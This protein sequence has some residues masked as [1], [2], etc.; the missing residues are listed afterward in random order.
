MENIRKNYAFLNQVFILYIA[1]FANVKNNNSWSNED[2]FLDFLYE[3]NMTTK[4]ADHKVKIKMQWLQEK[5]IIKD[6][7]SNQ[8]RNVERPQF[9]SIIYLVAVG[10]FKKNLLVQSNDLQKGQKS[11]QP[12]KFIK[13]FELQIMTKL[14]TFLNKFEHNQTEKFRREYIWMPKTNDILRDNFEYLDLLYCFYKT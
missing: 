1:R 6:F 8:M 3:I 11:M 9:I 10:M 2:N 5:G 12:Q 7:E 4:S 13:F 14:K